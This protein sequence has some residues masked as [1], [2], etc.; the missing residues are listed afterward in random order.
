M[1]DLLT[2]AM[3]FAPVPVLIT[4]R[5]AIIVYVNRKFLELSGYER[6]ELIGQSPRMLSAKLTPVGVYRELWAA[7]LCG[8]VWTGELCNKRK[9]GSIY[10]ELISIGPIRDK[11]GLIT[12]FI[13]IWQD[14]TQSKE[15]MR[16][17][18]KDSCTDELTG[19][20]NRRHIMAELE[21]EM[22]R[23]QRYEHNLCVMMV[24]ID[25]LKRI[26]DAYG[27]GFGD[28]ILRTFARIFKT[29]TRKIDITGRY[30]GDEFLVILPETSLKSASLIAQRIQDSIKFYQHNIVGD[31]VSCSASF[32]LFSL[33]DYESCGMAEFIQKADENLLEAKRTGKNRIVAKD[34]S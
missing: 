21:K 28:Q 17:L 34:W 11:S 9:N 23:A 8:H 30:G 3:D 16:K 31:F 13:G 22:N 32:G 4:N 2:E 18:E 14:I 19:V 10:W 29:A 12:H 20:Y 33:Q 15:W 25:N 1:D 5:E 27:H 26:N 6:R 7:I 24:D